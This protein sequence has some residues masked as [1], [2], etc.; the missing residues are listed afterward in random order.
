MKKIFY[1]L[2]KCIA[3]F[4]LAFVILNVFSYFYDYTPYNV[5]CESGTTDFAFSPKFIGYNNTEGFAK[6]SID[7]NGYNN[8]SIPENIDVLCMGSSHTLAYTVNPGEGYPALLGKTLKSELGWNVYNVGMIGHEWYYCVDNL[9]AALK[10]YA[11]SKYIVMESFYDKFE[12]EK[13][14][15]LLSGNYPDAGSV[16]SAKMR[17]IK[18]NPFLQVVGRQ[19]KNMLGQDSTVEN[20]TIEKKESFEEYEKI[21]DKTFSQISDIVN[22]YGCKYVFLYHPDIQVNENGQAEAVEDEKYM[23]LNKKLCDKYDFLFV[24]MTEDF[25]KAYQEEY[26]LPRGFV[27]TKMGYG[28]LNKSGHIMIADK[29]SKV[30]VED[31]EKNR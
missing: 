28:H 23:M 17:V 18:K 2:F 22:K 12:I 19:L 7:K 5:E 16:V 6:I 24:D 8:E 21:L 4:C 26:I 25:L 11:P 29:L 15:T 13:L 30:I 3:A 20:G 9:E 10:E 1:N 27:N 14:N 31:E